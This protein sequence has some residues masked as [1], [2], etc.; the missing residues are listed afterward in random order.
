[1]SFNFV[2]AALGVA[3]AV[4]RSGDLN[5]LALRASST[6]APKTSWRQSGAGR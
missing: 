6:L 1:V 5:T 4:G 2:V 3:R